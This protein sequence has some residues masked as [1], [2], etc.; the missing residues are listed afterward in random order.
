MFRG[1]V[2]GMSTFRLLLGALVAMVALQANT[3][4][5]G[6]IGYAQAT[7]YFKK[8]SRPTLYQ[9]LNLLDARDATAWCSATSDPLNELLTFGFKAPV[10]IEELRINSG[11][12][13]D[14]STWNDYSRARKIVV[15]SGKQRQTLSI[16]DVRGVQSVQLNPPMIGTRFALEV[17][18]HY[19]AEDPDAPVCLTDVVF[20]SEGK[21]LNGPWLTTKLKYDKAT[22]LV[23]GTWYAGF[24]GT[25]D[26]FLSLN[27][28]GTFSY[29]Y[30]PFDT[31]RNEEKVVRGTYDASTSRIVFEI[32]GKKHSVKFTREAAKKGGHTLAFEGELPEDLKGEWRS[33]P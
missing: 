16:E 18:D 8:D 2:A 29:S 13:F 25:P 17:L 21:A 23:M 30:E 6:G 31:T 1:I 28:D 9:P 32:G 12:N 19:P 7:G 27:F 5:A 10:R 22:A 3:A 33:L 4:N 11:N 15:R 14:A 24:E 26:R 20:V